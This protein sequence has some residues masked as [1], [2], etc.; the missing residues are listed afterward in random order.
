MTA[1]MAVFSLA[2]TLNMMGVRLHDVHTA[3]FTP[4]G[5]RRTVADAGALCDTAVS[6]PPRGVPDGVS[7][8]RAAER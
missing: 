1:A 4:S 3:D 7:Y 6:E 8:E 2:L 5:V